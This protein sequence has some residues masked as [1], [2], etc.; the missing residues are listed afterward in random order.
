MIQKIVPVKG[1]NGTI[2]IP[3]DKS[4]SHRSI[5]L[6]ALA[7]GV[8]E[9]EGFLMGADCLSTVSCFRQLGI[10]IQET[11]KQ[12]LTIEGRGLMG[13]SEPK[14][15]LNVGNSGTTMRLMLGLLAGQSFYATLTGDESI[16]QRPMKRVTQPLSNMGAQ[17]FGRK[18]GTLA[19]LSVVGQTLKPITYHSPVASAQVKSAILLAGLYANGETTVIEPALSR[20]HSERMLSYFGAQVKRDG[21]MVSIQGQP[22]LV[23][24]KIS[25]PGD[26]SSAAFFMVAGS[27]LPDSELVIEN[28]GINPTRNGIITVLQEMG[29]KISL[30]QEREETGEP[31][32][33]IHVKTSQLKGI[34]IGGDMIPTL[35][36]EIPIIAVAAA[37]AEG[38]TEIRDAAELKVK[39]TN[40][41]EVMAKNLT[42][43]GVRVEELP[44]G[45][46]IYGSSRIK[47]VE[48]NSFGDHRIAMSLA[49]AGLV[50]SG[51]TLINEAECATISYPRFFEDIKKL[52]VQGGK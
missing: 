4:I 9:V 10:T 14:D 43:M 15:V 21:L 13:L 31:V 47:G 46:I 22:H 11:A 23:G 44:D 8:T 25:V 50:A 12:S 30:Q 51:E 19:P 40:R 45:L 5:M 29:A 33:D 42:R 49:I 18:R 26:I 35:I 17:I 32:A 36:D 38:K 1:L 48:V 24:K 16:R 7:E 3:G 41:I 39:E 37:L 34:K 2:K 20:D 52:S 6:G 27:I 28:V